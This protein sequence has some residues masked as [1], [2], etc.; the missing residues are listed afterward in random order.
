MLPEEIT[1]VWPLA[2]LVAMRRTKLEK[3]CSLPIAL[4]RRL[5]YS[6]T[7]SGHS[8]V[9]PMTRRR[10]FYYTFTVKLTET[11]KIFASS[12]EEARAALARGVVGPPFRH[13]DFEKDPDILKEDIEQ[14]EI[15]LVAIEDPM[16]QI[17]TEERERYGDMPSPLEI[18]KALEER[19]QRLGARVAALEAREDG[20][21]KMIGP[22]FTSASLWRGSLSSLRSSDE[23][24]VVALANGCRSPGFRC[25]C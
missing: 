24:R 19:W 1:R 18:A 8:R 13:L 10:R 21:E 3:A 4:G 22:G 12:E 16:G 7:S 2:V 25:W 5:R 15:G 6:M 9:D 20:N 23:G 11:V 14:G 17:L